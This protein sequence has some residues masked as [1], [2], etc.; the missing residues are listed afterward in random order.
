MHVSL[1]SDATISHMTDIDPATLVDH[2]RTSHARFHDLIANLTDE[3]ARAASALPDWSRGHVITHVANHGFAFARQVEFALRGEQ[4]E[5]Y[6]GGRPGRNAGIE[7]GAGRP[8][9]E[10][11]RAVA[12]SNE[13]LDGLYA[14][15]GAEDW[16]RPVRYRDG[17]LLDTVWCRWR[18]VEVHAVDADLG[19]Q[20]LNW[21]PEFCAHL[22][23]FLT[24]RVPNGVELMLSPT[25]GDRTFLLG[26]GRRVELRGRLTDLTAWLAGRR[27]GDLDGELVELSPWP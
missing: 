14:K 18:E 8:A 19:Y 15:A 4:I 3:Q 22:V 12:E 24:P 20:A 2:V 13:L 21:S 16:A 11:V 27:Y 26:A 23:D 25:D 10:L 6:D 5:V 1:Q 9:A 7:A 17:V